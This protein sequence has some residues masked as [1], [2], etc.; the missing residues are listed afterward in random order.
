MN[1]SSERTFVKSIP[2][3]RSSFIRFANMCAHF[4]TFQDRE[5]GSN[6]VISSSSELLAN[7]AR[8]S[9]TAHRR[10]ILEECLDFWPAS[11][12]RVNTEWFSLS[13]RTSCVCRG[14]KVFSSI[15]RITPPSSTTTSANFSSLYRVLLFCRAESSMLPLHCAICSTIATEIRLSC[16]YHGKCIFSALPPAGL[17]SLSLVPR[18]RI[19]L[20]LAMYSSCSLPVS[21]T[22][23]RNLLWF[24]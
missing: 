8:R 23:F 15:L 4:L 2:S 6:A 17:F 11:M 5:V 20:S 22:T 10:S 13:S 1:C 3:T 19:R 24:Q 21:L 12:S 18:S 9:L 16:L 7:T 14:K